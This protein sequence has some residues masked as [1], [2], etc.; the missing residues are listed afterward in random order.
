MILEGFYEV[1]LGSNPAGKI[2]ITKQG[3]YSRIVCRCIVPQDVVYRLYAAG[4]GK[5]ENL[6]VV[7]PDG[8]GYL[9]ERSIVSKRLEGCTQFLLS[10]RS[11]REV[12][13]FVPIYPEEPFSYIG[14]LENTFLE[15][16]NGQPGIRLMENP[17]AV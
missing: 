9:L 8:E 14:Q 13:K 3:L 7:I 17:G 10:A 2:Q 12:G 16:Q 5:R 1:Y 6:G 15:I 4:N 11:D